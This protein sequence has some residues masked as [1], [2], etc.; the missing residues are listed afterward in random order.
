MADEL[1]CSRS[2]C[3]TMNNHLQPQERHFEDPQQRHTFLQTAMKELPAAAECCAP[4]DGVLSL[5]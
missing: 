1:D 4:A 3:R 2:A 5:A